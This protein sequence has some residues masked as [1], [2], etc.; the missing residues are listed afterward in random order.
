MILPISTMAAG[1][2]RAPKTESADESATRACCN[3]ATRNACAPIPITT[4]TTISTPGHYCLANSLIGTGALITIISDD[5]LLD[6]NGQFLEVI[7]GSALEISSVTGTG[8]QNI[9]IKN[10]FLTSDQSTTSTGIIIDDVAFP[11]DLHAFHYNIVLEGLNIRLFNGTGIV[12][13]STE[14]LVIEC[15][16]L[17]SNGQNLFVNNSAEVNLIS[18][19]FRI[20]LTDSSATLFECNRTVMQNCAFTRNQFGGLTLNTCFEFYANNCHFNDNGD[21]GFGNGLDGILSTN[22]VFESCSFSFNNNTGMSLGDISLFNAYN[23]TFNENGFAGIGDGF[24]AIS[25]VPTSV[26]ND[27]VFDQCTFSANAAKGFIIEGLPGFC[28]G[29]KLLNCQAMNNTDHGFTFNNGA[30]D[31]V[32]E[33]CVSSGNTPGHGFVLTTTI[34]SFATFI[35]CVASDNTD[36]FNMVDSLG[37]GVIQECKAVGNSGTGSI[38]FGPSLV[39]CGFNDTADSLYQYI[40]CVAQGN[41]ANPAANMV[42]TTT[43]TNYCIDGVPTEYTPITGG[44]GVSEPFSQLGRSTFTGMFNAGITA[45]DNVTLK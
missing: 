32:L 14:K 36:G 25:A 33:N 39:G 10:G 42:S 28:V 29:F 40:S 17:D 41:G 6:L 35:G 38:G 21:S 20:S 34:G 12:A 43:D 1:K 4:I 2:R 18:S 45:W 16:N 19:A 26:I 27:F 44:P 7:S 9:I 37:S 11:T 8:L 13:N 30:T 15:C 3:R 5:V 22:L 23:C 24:S 31:I